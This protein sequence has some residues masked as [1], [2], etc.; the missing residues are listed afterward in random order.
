MVKASSITIGI[1]VGTTGLKAVALDVE[2]GIVATTS[3]ANALL[4]PHAGWAEADPGQWFKNAADA[5]AELSVGFGADRIV[6]I[7]TTGMVPAFVAVGAD[8]RPVRAAMLQN[9]ARAAAEVRAIAAEL[10]TADPLQITG[11]PVTQQSVAPT[12]RWL[13][14][15][16][17]ATWQATRVVVGSYDWL[18]M[19][20]GAEPHVERN[21]AIE[22]GLFQLDGTPF[23]MA[24]SAG[25]MEA[26]LAPIRPSASVVGELSIEAAVATA[27]DPGIPLVVGGADHVL[28]AYGAGLSRDGEWLIKLGGAGDILATSTAPLVD[29][30]FYLD[31]HPA[32]GLWLPNG[33]MATS[34]SLVRW[35]QGLLGVQDLMAMDDVAQ[36][37]RPA[38]VLCLPYFLGEKSPLNDPDL[39][40]V[41][42]GLHLGHDGVDLYRAALE[43][44]A[45]GFRHNA[46]ALTDAGA[47]LAEAT[48]TN[49]GATSSLWKRIHASVLGV[50]L[51]T[52]VD[53]PGAALGAAVAAA[54]GVGALSGWDEIARFVHPGPTVDPDPEWLKRYDDAYAIWRELSEVSAAPMRALARR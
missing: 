13:A 19:A 2:S 48:V 51:R 36:K 53:H 34:G 1:D 33:C 20:L 45:F 15:H 32:P 3:R 30:R 8:G 54:I 18:L 24:V 5:V 49:G 29:A 42:A 21:W 25:G 35:V 28:S 9:D 46:E 39:R 37:R 17:P 26:R 14:A 52:V 10:S 40:G 44:I 31:E 50:S 27:L 6:G 47:N 23:D 11:S 38:E 41:F 4:S 12:A 7:G 16:E 43:G 22:S